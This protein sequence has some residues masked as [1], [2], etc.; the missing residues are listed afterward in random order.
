MNEQQRGSITLPCI[1]I[2]FIMLLLATG[3]LAFTTREYEHTRTYLRSRQLRLLAASALAQAGE[4]DAGSAVLLEHVF[5]PDKEKVLLT[6]TKTVSSD[7]LI[8]KTEAAAET[9]NHVGAVQRFKQYSFRITER[10]Q[11]LA[12][13]YALIGARF[14]GLEHLAA[15]ARYIQAQEVSLPQVSFMQGVIA[16]KTAQSMVNDG[17]SSACYYIDGSYNFPTG[18]KIIAGSSVF[19]AT[20]N[21]K[22]NAN[23]R[24]S[25]RVVLISEKGTITIAKNCS[26]ANALIMAKTVDVGAGCELTGCIIA[27]G[28]YLNGTG[29]FT[30]SPAAAEPFISALNVAEDA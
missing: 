12:Q 25:G 30:P 1:L 19:V 9:A 28:I 7:G 15:E 17:L 20:G 21:I 2:A 16:N 13:E 22:I 18:G 26:F 11:A 27:S 10:Q 29:S 3:M 14:T 24:F 6:L 23:T 8:S 5:Y 4:M